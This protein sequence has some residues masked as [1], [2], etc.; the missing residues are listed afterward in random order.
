MKQPTTWRNSVLIALIAAFTLSGHFSTDGHAAAGLSPL[1]CEGDAC[2]AVTVTFDD[3]KQQY[4]AANVT[5]DRWVRVSAANE[6]ASA[7]ACLAPGK[8]AYLPLK[9]V[10]APYRAAFAEPRCGAPEGVGR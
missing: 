2:P 3:A 1:E 8:E 5:S 10:V 7:S 6:A 4:R 9:S